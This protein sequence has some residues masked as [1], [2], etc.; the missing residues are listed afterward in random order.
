MWVDEEFNF[1]DKEL[2]FVRLLLEDDN[3]R[4]A[5]EQAKQ[6]PPVLP[7]MTSDGV[8]NA[9]KESEYDDEL[10]KWKQAMNGNTHS[11]ECPPGCAG[12]HS[13]ERAIFE[14]TNA[15]KLKAV[16][17]LK[18]EGNELFKT[19]EYAQACLSYRRGLVF[20]DYTFPE[21]F[22]ETQEFKT[23]EI[24]LCMNLA[25]AKEK[26]FLFSEA[27]IFAKRA[28]QRDP[29]NPKAWFRIGTSFLGLDRYEDAEVSLKKA[30]SLAPGDPGIQ[31]QLR[32]LDVRKSEYAKREKEMARRIVNQ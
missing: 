7:K 12:D 24:A 19:G 5:R 14:K 32:T 22:E 16:T 9:V 25:A 26:Q 31:A 23:L 6:A 3:K 28:S 17:I 18:N 8:E 27:L 15:E 30:L 2:E 4:K 13:A 11:E 1:K 20:L 21:S 10:E 29:G